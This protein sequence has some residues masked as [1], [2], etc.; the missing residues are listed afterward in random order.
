MADIGRLVMM[1]R[2]DRVTSVPHLAPDQHLWELLRAVA[3]SGDA[4]WPALLAELEPM[5]ALF[6]KRQP[7]GRLRDREDTP[8]EIVTRVFA[9][10]HA[11]D[12]AAVRKLCTLD[13]APELRAWLRVLVRRSAIDYMRE[14]PEFERSA[15]RW[16]SLATLSSGAP[17]PDPD[18]LAGKRTELLAFVRAAVDHA[19]GEFSAHGELAFTRLALEWKI[20]RI[21]VRRLVTRGDQYIAV[22]AGV[23]E[24]HSYPEVAERLA[25]TRREVELTVRYLEELLRERGFGATPSA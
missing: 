8:R 22:L 13:P 20:G 7:I 4:A 12:F 24:G 10:L 15:N 19:R 18:S 17:S 23:L 3:A 14:V 5:L 11:R 21:H 25:I 6:A 16:V 2:V 1:A 9:R